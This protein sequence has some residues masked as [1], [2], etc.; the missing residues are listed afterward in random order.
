MPKPPPRRTPNPGYRDPREYLKGGF[1]APGSTEV[2]PELMTDRAAS[3]GR[4]LL[5]EAVPLEV[6]TAAFKELEALR[7]LSGD[8]ME[9]RRRLSEWAARPGYQRYPLLAQLL[10]TGVGLVRKPEDLNAFALHLRR[11]LTLATFERAL[12]LAN[13]V[14]LDRAHRRAQVKK[15]RTRRPRKP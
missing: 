14:E 1:F 6:V 12:A 7:R 2:R 5:I 13:S 8:W 9:A 11:I 15:A 4:E 3:M 10:N